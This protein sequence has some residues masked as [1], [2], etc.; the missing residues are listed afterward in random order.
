[1]MADG[2]KSKSAKVAFPD[3]V[4]DATMRYDADVDAEMEGLGRRPRGVTMV[5]ESWSRAAGGIE[6]GGLSTE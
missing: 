5:L 1:M 6:K 3:A 2:A 4:E